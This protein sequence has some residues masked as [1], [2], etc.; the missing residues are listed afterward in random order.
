MVMKPP[1]SRINPY[2]GTKT[3]FSA[4]HYPTPEVNVPGL[5]SWILNLVPDYSTKL[6]TASDFESF[7]ETEDM[8]KVILVSSKLQV[9]QLYGA[10]TATYRDR[11]NFA[12]VSDESP[13]AKQVK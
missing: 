4:S 3:P 10:L 2:D 12:F 13:V 5:K 11:I 7:R 8:A 9:P 1:Y 6:Y